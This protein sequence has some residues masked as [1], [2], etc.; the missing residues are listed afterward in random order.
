MSEQLAEKLPETQLAGP[1]LP[2]RASAGLRS[3]TIAGGFRVDVASAAAVVQA[4]RRCVD[5]GRPVHVCTLNPEISELA[6]ED[7]A[8]YDAV[9]AADL[10]T[11]DGVGISAAVWRQHGDFPPRLTGVKLLYA[12]A[13]DAAA[14]GREVVIVGA[15]DASRREAESRLRALGVPVRDGISP[16]VGRDGVCDP[17]PPG[18][19]PRGGVVLVALGPPKQEMWIRRQ[20]HAGAPP[21]IYLGVGGGVDYV[22]GAAPV[23]PRPVRRLGLQWL[24]RL[25]T[26]PRTRLPRQWHT[27]P[28]FLWRQVVRA[29]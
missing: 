18:L 4:C 16:R 7:P 14:C 27:L 19:L 26:D 5:A 10:T 23:P 28:K 25:L 29:R 11:I 6:L 15:S 12:L 17:L 13:R 21:A 9:T 8:Y 3:Y 22:S 20:L 2:A 24:Y 1:P